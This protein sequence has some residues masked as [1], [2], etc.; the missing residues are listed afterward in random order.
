MAGIKSMFA[1]LGF[2]SLTA[3]S[4]SRNMGHDGGGR[5]QP[6]VPGESP[7]ETREARSFL[8]VYFRDPN[9]NLVEVSIYEPA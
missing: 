1:A 7:P 8:M 6:Q 9:L 4:W 5:A 3:I 2:F